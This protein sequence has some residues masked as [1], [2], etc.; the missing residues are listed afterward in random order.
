MSYNDIIQEGIPEGGSASLKSRLIR[1]RKWATKS[2]K[3]TVHG[4]L[5]IVNGEA[6]DGTRNAPVLVFEAA[7][8]DPRTGGV[9]GG[10]SSSSSMGGSNKHMNSIASSSSVGGGGGSNAIS[11]SEV[12]CGAI[13]NLS[14]RALYDRSIGCQVRTVRELKKDEIALSIPVS[15]MI[16]P[17]LIALSDAGQ[18]ILACCSSAS[19]VSAGEDTNKIFWNTF[20]VTSVLEQKQFEKISQNSGTQLLVKIL[21]ERKRVETAL[22]KGGEIAMEVKERGGESGENNSMHP[23]QLVP[24]GSISHRAPFLAFLIHQRFANEQSPQVAENNHLISEDIPETFAPYART[25]PSSVCVPI[26]WKRNELALLAGCIPGMPALQKVAAR[27]MQLAMEIVTLVDAGLLWRFPAIFAPGMITWDRW[28][29]AAAIYE[30]R[31]VSVSSLP[32]WIW[33]DDS[34]C[35]SR[36]WESCGVMVPFL[37]MLNHEDNAAQ[38]SW[39]KTNTDSDGD[40]DASVKRLNLITDEKTKKHMQ[41]YRNY[42]ILDNEHFMLQYGFTRMSN[43][44]D[45]VRIAWALVDGVGGV[46]PPKD[47]EP[48]ESACSRSIPTSQLVYESSDPESLKAWWTEHRLTLLGFAV[49]NNADTLESLKRGKKVTYCAFNNGKIDRGLLAVAVV[50]TLPPPTVEKMYSKLSTTTSSKPLEGF[51]LDKVCQNTVQQYLRFLFSKKLEKLLQS[52]NSCLKDHFN[53][54]QLWTKASMGGLN[55]AAE[56][57]DCAMSFEG[58]GGENSSTVVGW[59]S[60]FDNYVWYST[61]EVEERY[62]SMAPDSCVLTLYDGHVRSLQASLD[63]LAADAALNDTVK[64]LLEDLGCVLDSTTS[65]SMLADVKPIVYPFAAVGTESVDEQETLKNSGQEN[66]AQDPPKKDDQGSVGLGTSGQGNG[67]KRDRDRRKDKTKGDRPPAI[68]LHIGNLSYKTLPNQLYDFFTGLYGKGSVLEC[69][70]PT[71]R[72]TGNSRGFGFVTMPDTHAKAAL[73]SG[74]K[75]EMDGRILKVAE[76]NSVGSGKANKGGRN[77]MPPAPSS[78][79]CS[80]CGYR[81]RWCTCNPSMMPM[82]MGRGGPPPPPDYMYGMRQYMPPPH[83][84]SG[85][86]Y[87]HP[88]DMDDRHMGGGDGQGWGGGNFG[89]VGNRRS[90]SRSPS[91]RRERDRGYRRSRSYSRSRSR[92]YS[93]GRDRSDRHR[94]R[95][96]HDDGRRRYD[97]DSRRGS[98]RRYRSKSRSRSRQR[99]GPVSPNRGRPND[100]AGDFSDD[101]DAERS[102]SRS[103]SPNDSNAM[104]HSSKKREGK[105]TSSRGDGRSR[106]RDHGSRR[107]KRSKGSRRGSKR[108]GGSRS[109]SRE[110]H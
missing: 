99:D 5:C 21:Q 106:S 30:S 107:R 31:V 79:R 45:K 75:H 71:E 1:F 44:A 23:K 40:G 91:Y 34:I 13:D 54:V 103:L 36:I 97:D 85:P 52:L 64:L 14:D 74:R 37:D 110:R 28:V 29:W 55:Y 38:V 80:N 100:D 104:D 56:N 93:R 82:N 105:D 57:I 10:S 7:R 72:D 16:T 26:C 60:F 83:M 46:A 70:I 50:A 68:K 94:D 66:K 77:N 87:G 35:S 73:E 108:R 101:P 47:Y 6:T 95:G 49:Q 4:A 89:V 53:S 19:S 51:V 63:V 27:T 22:M 92:S 98:S 9:G 32:S 61:M 42:G 81:P 88:H 2:A 86:G 67:N 76:S 78:D 109:R 12:R 59:Q 39:K 11:S 33:S 69:H 41:I 3:I 48:D 102:L 65:H 84:G 90:W 8:P 58:G 62:Y 43:P 24:S 20:G 25:L 18:A 17:D 15:A 96:R